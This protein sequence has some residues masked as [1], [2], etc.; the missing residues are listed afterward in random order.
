[1]NT[2]RLWQSSRLGFLSLSFAL[3]VMLF[4]AIALAAGVTYFQG[5]ETDTYDWVGATRV[6]SG[7]NGV[8]SAAG[9]WHAESSGGTLN[10]SGAFTRW[11]GYGGNAGC[12]TSACAAATFP[13]NG[14][15]TSLDVYLDV[16]GLST[17]DT[18]FD[19]SSAINTPS[20]TH[21]RDFV[22][23]A[24][25]Y[26]DTDVTGTGPRLL[27]ARAPTPVAQTRFPRTRQGIRSRLLMPAGIPFSTLSPTM[28]REC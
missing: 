9:A 7:T 24:G 10:S 15:I 26:N 13:E 5:F 16:D 19:F 21:R 28:V 1:M 2:R 12:T 25:F 11:G 6:A 22:F 3:S 23:N 8:I 20:G 4:G 18:R 27:S 17:N 14:Y